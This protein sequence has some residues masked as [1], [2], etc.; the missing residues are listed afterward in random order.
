MGLENG[1]II[2][3]AFLRINTQMKNLVPLLAIILFLTAKPALAET[4]VNVS[5]SSSGG[6][7][8]HIKITENGVTKE[9]NSSDCS[10]I[11]LS[12]DSSGNVT[13]NTTTPH[14]SNPQSTTSPTHRPASSPLVV[15][16]PTPKPTDSPLPSSSSQPTATPQ[17]Q[18]KSGFE[19]LFDRIFS[20]FHSIFG[21]FDKK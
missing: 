12:M 20:V 8:S 17:P 15:S 5:N 7:N 14:S 13:Q 2:S 11:S 16:S 3:I 4:S 9:I 21:A 10:D 19:G 6:C 1:C 18:P